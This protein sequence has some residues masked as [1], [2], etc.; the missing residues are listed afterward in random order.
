ML[1]RLAAL[2]GQSVPEQPEPQGKPGALRVSLILTDVTLTRMDPARMTLPGIDLRIVEGG[3]AAFAANAPLQRRTDVVVIE[4]DPDNAREVA[5][6]EDFAAANPGRLPV[7]AAVRDL[8][9]PVT[10]R[11]LRSD[12]A[13]V[14]PIPF[15]IEELSQAIETGRD[16][17]SQSRSAQGPSRLGHIIAI[18]SAMGGTGGTMLASQIAQI[19]SEKRSV[20]LIDLDV[21]QGNAALYLNLK[22]RLSIADLVEADDRLDGEFLRMVAERHKSGLSVI[23]APSDMTPMDALSP[24]FIDRLLDVAAQ[25]FDLVIVDLPGIWLDWTAAA[26]QK[27]D[28]IA[29]VTVMT[30]PGIHQARRQLDVIEANTLSDR[31]RIVLNRMPVGMFGKI[32]VSEAESALRHRVHFAISND[33]PTVSSAIDEGK[34]I[35]QIKMKSRVEK[36]IRQIAVAVAEE[37]AQMGVLA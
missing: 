24:D 26:M 30:V 15:N 7:I 31:V 2:T 23:A 36:D 20:C 25:Q 27:S 12:I 1:A 18:Q 34:L 5:A 35:S 13:D 22:P 33:Y 9:V 32:D 19:W 16:R 4:L 8:T 14:L 11:L 17:I 29:L 21:Q 3:L 28:V 37:M 6:L 10:R